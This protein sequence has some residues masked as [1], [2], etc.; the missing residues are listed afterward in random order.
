MIFLISCLLVRGADL[1]HARA[2]TL[3]LLG[4]VEYLIRLDSQGIHGVLERLLD[5]QGAVH[6][7]DGGSYGRGGATTESKVN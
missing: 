2:I 3:L 4:A 5:P 7:I 1:W 6:G